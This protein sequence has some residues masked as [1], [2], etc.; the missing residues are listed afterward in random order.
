MSGTGT[1]MPWV[2]PSYTDGRDGHV[3]RFTSV[4]EELLS[5]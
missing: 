3:A 2:P 4:G 5:S 1:S